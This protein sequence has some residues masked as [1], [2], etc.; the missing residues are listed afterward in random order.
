MGLAKIFAI[1][2][3]KFYTQISNIRIIKLQSAT[4]NKIYFYI[5][6]P[7][8]NVKNYVGKCIESLLAQSYE[9]FSAVFV[10][11]GSTDE[12][13]EIAKSFVAKD[14]RL[15]FLS[16]KNMGVS[17]ARNSA[18]NYIFANGG[19]QHRYEYIAFL[20]SDDYLESNALSHIAEFLSKNQVGVFVSN[21]FFEVGDLSTNTK[22]V[23]QKHIG[24]YKIFNV[25]LENQI[26]TT[27]ELVQN[28]PNAEFTTIGAFVFRADI[29][30]NIRFECGVI[31]GEDNIFSTIAALE[32]SD[33]YIDSTPIYNYRIRLNSS[34]R[35]KNY[36]DYANSHFKVAK[37]FESKMNTQSDKIYKIFYQNSTKRA[38]R[39]ILEYLQYCGYNASLNFSKKDLEPFLPLIKG[40]RRFCYHFPRIYGIPKKIR[41]NFV[42]FFHRF[43]T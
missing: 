43:K 33:I 41:K 34:S 38:V 12:S 4:N 25:A 8:Y 2:P 5:I 22:N 27:K 15:V 14:S 40:K 28:Y 9:N 30:H 35:T 13:A 21:R 10:D 24:G 11:D 31:S 42:A 20:D 17:V 7:I 36:I 32:S 18:L 19:G 6:I 29:I 3:R 16:Q 1:M 37:F 26:T 23:T 39:H